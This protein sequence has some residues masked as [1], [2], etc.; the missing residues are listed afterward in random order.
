MFFVGLYCIP[1]TC[2]SVFSSFV[3][4]ILTEPFYRLSALPPTFDVF[5]KWNGYVGVCFVTAL[6]EL[7]FSRNIFVSSDVAASLHKLLQ[8]LDVE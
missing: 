2:I 1:E 5:D 7:C 6:N 4:P 3:Y 8:Y